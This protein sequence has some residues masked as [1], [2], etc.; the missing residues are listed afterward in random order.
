MAARWSR[1]AEPAQPKEFEFRYTRR[2]AFRAPA[3]QADN[4]VFILNCDHKKQF[5]TPFAVNKAERLFGP[6]YYGDDELCMHMALEE[7]DPGADAPVEIAHCPCTRASLVDR[8]GSGAAC[9][10]TLPKTRSIGL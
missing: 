1:S 7:I 2:P 9:S 5:G 8:T 4:Y 6:K 3:E 10:E